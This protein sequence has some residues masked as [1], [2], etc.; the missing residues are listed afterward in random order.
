MNIPNLL[1]LNEQ[2]GEHFE[3]SELFEHNVY[4]DL[5]VDH[6]RGQW[7]KSITQKQK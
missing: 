3:Q 7:M 1:I 5:S 2:S 6:N 4:D